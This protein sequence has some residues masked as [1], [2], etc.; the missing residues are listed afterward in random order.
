VYTYWRQEPLLW[1]RLAPLDPGRLRTLQAA[2][3]VQ[4]V[5]SA[6][7]ALTLG[8][9]AIVGLPRTA[10]AGL[11]GLSAVAIASAFAVYLALRPA[12]RRLVWPASP[13]AP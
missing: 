10:L 8:S 7:L 12:A 1:E 6:A 5:G 4:R 11:L 3:M 13:T 2:A 9:H